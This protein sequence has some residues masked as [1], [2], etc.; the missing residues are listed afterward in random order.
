M[1]FLTPEI[2]P[3]SISFLIFLTFA[4]LEIMVL[5]L[6]WGLFDFLDDILPT[7]QSDLDLNSNSSLG[8]F[9]S[10]V[11]PNKVPFS[12]VLISLFFVFSFI[13]TLLINIFGL[14]PLFISLPIT[15]VLTLFSLRHITSLIAKVLPKETSEVVSTNSFIGKKVLILDSIAKRDLPARAK[16]KDIYGEM[17]YIRVEPLNDNDTFHEGENVLI[18]EKK[19]LIFF[20]EKTLNF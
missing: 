1:D 10:Y 3:Y 15:F 8:D 13:G 12:M 4:F 6:G 11:N 7:S 20:V 19:G 16:I 5:I 14:L 18:I 2:L 9:F 17:H